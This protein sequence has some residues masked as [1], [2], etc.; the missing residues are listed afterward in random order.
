MKPKIMKRYYRLSG[1]EPTKA[2]RR[3]QYALY[4]MAMQDLRLY[5]HRLTVFA[6]I[7][8][9]NEMQDELLRAVD[10]MNRP[11]CK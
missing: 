10:I 5:L 9:S 11:K 2:I 7:S 8:G 1:Q 3:R 4:E 6:A